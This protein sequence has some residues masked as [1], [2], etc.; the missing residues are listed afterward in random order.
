MASPESQK[1]EQA[2]FSFA[3]DGEVGFLFD[4]H[5][6]SVWDVSKTS[7]IRLTLQLN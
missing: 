4:T 3:F 6:S 5:S 2:C 1:K 7:L